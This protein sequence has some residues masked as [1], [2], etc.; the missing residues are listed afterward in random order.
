[1]HCGVAGTMDNPLPCLYNVHFHIFCL[2]SSFL[3][4]SL[5]SI[6]NVVKSCFSVGPLP[7]AEQIDCLHREWISYPQHCIQFLWRHSNDTC[8]SQLCGEHV[9]FLQTTHGNPPHGSLQKGHVYEPGLTYKASL[10][11]LELCYL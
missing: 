7:H 5:R 3:F 1:M 8:S 4:F 6:T 10:R 11:C 2:L 9:D